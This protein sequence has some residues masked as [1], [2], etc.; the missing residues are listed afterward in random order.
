[1]TS[2][3]ADLSFLYYETVKSIFI[4]SMP[5][6]CLYGLLFSLA[7]HNLFQAPD[8]IPPHAEDVADFGLSL[9]LS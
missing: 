5:Y 6:P 8:S 2:S 9:F 4:F 3:H 7:L 1:M